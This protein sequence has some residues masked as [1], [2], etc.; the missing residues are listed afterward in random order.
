MRERGGIE[1]LIWGVSWLGSGETD[2]SHSMMMEV[3][4]GS[5]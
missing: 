2:N 5:I 3:S 1:V 4:N